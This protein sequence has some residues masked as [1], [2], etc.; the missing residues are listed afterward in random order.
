MTTLQFD[1]SGLR[2]KAS[3]S[4]AR[5]IDP[6]G[7]QPLLAGAAVLT[8]PLSVQLS[9][10]RHGAGVSFAGTV[11]GEW[12]L[13]CVR[14]LAPARLRF[15]IGVEGEAPDAGAALDA[16]EEV[17]QALHLALP[18]NARCRP[19]CKGLCPQCGGSRN[20]KE[21]GCRPPEFRARRKDA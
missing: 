19:D 9:V 2:E 5:R 20:E 21:C 16:S 12:E 1:L 17:R 11:E 13:A 18:L 8:G 10:A 14:C 3:L 15:R 6:Q 4:F 7:L